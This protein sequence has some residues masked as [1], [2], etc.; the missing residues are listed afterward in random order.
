[1]HEQNA[2]HPME[3]YLAI[4]RNEVLMH[5]AAWVNLENIMQLKDTSQSQKATYCN[6]STYMKCL[7]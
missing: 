4:K 5:A 1:M 3:S 6:D 7:V 2:V